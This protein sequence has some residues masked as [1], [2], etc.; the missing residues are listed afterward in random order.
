MRRSS[1]TTSRCGAS[2]AGGWRRGSPCIVSRRPSALSRAVGARDQAQHL[3]AVLG[4]DHARPESG[5]PLAGAG[6]ELVERA[7]DP[8]GLQAGKLHRQRLALGGDIEQPLAAV[9]LA[10]LLHDI[11]LVDE[12]LEHAAERLLGDLQDVEQSATFMPGLRLTK[13]STRWC[14]RPK[15]SLASTSSGSLTKSR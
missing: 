9:V 8:L 3:V 12:L 13:C 10:L 7:R 14:A 4:V 15:P 11:A 5:A 2:S 1:S 6:A